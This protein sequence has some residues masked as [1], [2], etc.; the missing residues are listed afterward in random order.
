MSIELQ[1]A[2]LAVL[3]KEPCST[4]AILAA[5]TDFPD[6]AACSTFLGKMYKHG[7]IKKQHNSYWKLTSKG[8]GL[9]NGMDVEIDTPPAVEPDSAITQTELE[10]TAPIDKEE[11]KKLRQARK[12]LLNQP[13]P[14]TQ[15]PV[16]LST[17]PSIAD[18]QTRIPETASLVIERGAAFFVFA[19]HQFELTQEGDFE[20]FS[21]M[22]ECHIGNVNSEK[23]LKTGS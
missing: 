18:L 12:T 11:L 9:F 10:A 4:K 6:R 23:L 2:V 17:W 20:A 1:N 19:N 8:I 21:R 22:T 3:N 7:L 16:I 5:V 14:N 15:V 13:E